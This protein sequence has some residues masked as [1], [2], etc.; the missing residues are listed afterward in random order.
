MGPLMRP[1][2]KEGP[3]A[4]LVRPHNYSDRQRILY[5]AKN[6]GTVKVDGGNVSFYQDFSMEIVRR[7]RES[8]NAHKLLREAGIRYSSLYPAFIKIFHPVPAL[9]SRP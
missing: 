3:R 7:R 2:G 1:A 6:K 5:A 4:V 8:A 9:P